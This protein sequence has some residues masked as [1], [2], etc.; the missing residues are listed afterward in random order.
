MVNCLSQS[1]LMSLEIKKWTS[2]FKTLAIIE[3]NAIMNLYIQ[4]TLSALILL[5]FEEEVT[6]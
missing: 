1:H 6:W 4:V 3:K 5:F 2:L